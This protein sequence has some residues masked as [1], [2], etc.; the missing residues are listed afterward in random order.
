M[1]LYSHSSGSKIQVPA[2]VVLGDFMKD[3]HYQVVNEFQMVKVELR[4]VE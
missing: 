3:K 1:R 2:T 4:K